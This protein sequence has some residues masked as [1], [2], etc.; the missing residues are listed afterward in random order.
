MKQRFGVDTRIKLIGGE[1]H[2]NMPGRGLSTFQEKITR[3][4]RNANNMQPAFDEYGGYLVRESIPANFRREGTS[5]RQWKALTPA[6]AER[7]RRAGGN[8]GIL[9]FSGGLRSGFRHEATKRT[10]RVTNRRRVNG[11]SLFHVHQNGTR[12]RRLPSRAMVFLG[13]PEK[14]KFTEVVQRHLYGERR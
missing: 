3:F 5:Q 11:V 12:K 6:Y 9:D 13:T 8:A 7:K 4:S 14:H 1:L 2:F 10:L